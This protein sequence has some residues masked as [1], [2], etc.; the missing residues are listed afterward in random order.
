M[1]CGDGSIIY[2]A[3]FSSV[4]QYE[5][6]FCKMFL[7]SM[8]VYKQRVSNVYKRYEK[9]AIISRWQV[10]IFKKRW[11]KTRKQ[12]LNFQS[13]NLRWKSCVS[14][15]LGGSARW[16]SLFVSFFFYQ[17]SA[18]KPVAYRMWACRVSRKFLM[19]H[20]ATT[21]SSSQS[22]GVQHSTPGSWNTLYI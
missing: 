20:L 21:I 17:I 11:L 16:F 19:C 12:Q 2:D 8:T 22:L 4:T 5:V 9:H 3:F 14:S 7:F 15:R 6:H 18:L 1:L 13:D 10:D